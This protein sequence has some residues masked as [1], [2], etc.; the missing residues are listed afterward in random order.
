[1]VYVPLPEEEKRSSP[2]VSRHFEGVTVQGDN[3]DDTYVVE[4]VKE[5][6]AV[7]QATEVPKRKP[8]S[9]EEMAFYLFKPRALLALGA[10]MLV[11]Q[12]IKT[13]FTTY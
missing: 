5:F 8:H 11:F 3:S 2:P 1:M 6:S 7:L 13:A 9:S 12:F 4:C 10:G